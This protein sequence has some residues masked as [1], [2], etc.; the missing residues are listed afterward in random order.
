LFDNALDANGMP[1]AGSFEALKTIPRQGRAFM[2]KVD[3]ALAAGEIT[4]EQKQQ[5]KDLL[6]K[7]SVPSLN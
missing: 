6:V 3:T 1:R 2:A 5:L 7:H 4:E